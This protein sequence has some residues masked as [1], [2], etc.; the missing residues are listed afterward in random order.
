MLAGLFIYR[1]GRAQHREAE[2]IA[3]QVTRIVA[4]LDID[5]MRQSALLLTGIARLYRGRFQ[6]AVSAMDEAL[7][8]APNESAYNWGQD[9]SVLCLMFSSFA[10]HAIGRT[11]EA[12]ER[13]AR[14]VEIAGRGQD[15]HLLTTSMQFRSILLRWRGDVDE[16]STL[17][18]EVDTIS[19][20]H[21]LELWAPVTGWVSGWA[22]AT[23][24]D[25]EEG[26]REA[27]SNL[28]RY[29]ESGT[30][31]SR[32]DYMAATAELCLAAGEIERG[33]DW[34]AQALEASSLSGERIAEVEIH[35]VHAR[36]LAAGESWSELDQLG[37]G[38]TRALRTRMQNAEEAA[39]RAIEVAIAQEARSGRLR[40]TTTYLEIARH[41]PRESEARAQL[42]AAIDD[43]DVSEETNDLR[44]ARGALAQD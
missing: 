2:R 43:W 39:R 19:L 22:R 24:G 16:A 21:G 8:L 6:E 17:A 5:L 23:R 33:M 3:A 12:N 25:L 40:A 9:A 27:E 41:G 20:E 1:I 42:S 35:R 7:A 28:S 4:P 18:A 31:A 26:L 13:S 36:L 29:A 37:V 34:I 15:A 14:G 32:T 38:E 44:H 30:E 10:L 11:R